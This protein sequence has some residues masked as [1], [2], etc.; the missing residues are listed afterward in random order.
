[1]TGA[2]LRQTE[3]K[4]FVFRVLNELLVNQRMR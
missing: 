2:Y 4:G 3:H 1:M